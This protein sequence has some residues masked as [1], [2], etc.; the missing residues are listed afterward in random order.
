MALLLKG[1]IPHALCKDLEKMHWVVN[2][3]DIV[4]NMDTLEK[5]CPMFPNGVALVKF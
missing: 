4:R 5:L 3:L 2:A 1:A